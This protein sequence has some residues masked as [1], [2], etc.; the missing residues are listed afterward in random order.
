MKIKIYDMLTL[1][2][3]AAKARGANIPSIERVKGA[4]INTELEIEG[5]RTWRKVNFH[6]GETIPKEGTQ[7]VCRRK[8][9]N[10]LGTAVCDEFGLISIDIG[11]AEPLPL[12]GLIWL[13][14]PD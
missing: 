13:P 10:V 12:K 9:K 8:G 7:I 14:I 5:L 4:Y 3:L 2:R 6:D 1:F 11:E